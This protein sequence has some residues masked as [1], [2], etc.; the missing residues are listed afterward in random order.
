MCGAKS[1][2]N[3]K[4]TGSGRSPGLRPDGT[5]FNGGDCLR[6]MTPISTYSCPGWTG[7]NSIT[8]K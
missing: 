8:N 7:P 1:N 2:S 3:V 6:H 5:S 4:I